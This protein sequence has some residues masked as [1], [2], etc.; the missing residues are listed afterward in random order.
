MDERYAAPKP[1][2]ACAGLPCGELDARF[3]SEHSAVVPQI[4]THIDGVPDVLIQNCE[5][6]ETCV[7]SPCGELYARRPIF[8]P[9][10]AGGERAVALRGIIDDDCERSFHR[11]RIDTTSAYPPMRRGRAPCHTTGELSPI[12]EHALD[13][14]RAC[15]TPLVGGRL[16]LSPKVLFIGG[17]AYDRPHSVEAS[18]TCYE[19]RRG[20]LLVRQIIVHTTSLHL[21]LRYERS[22]RSGN[23]GIIVDFVR[24]LS[25]RGNMHMSHTYLVASCDRCPRSRDGGLLT[26]SLEGYRRWWTYVRSSHTLRGLAS[27][28]PLQDGE[29]VVDFHGSRRSVAGARRAARLGTLDPATKGHRGLTDVLTAHGSRRGS[30]GRVDGMPHL[31]LTLTLKALSASGYTY[32][33][34]APSRARRAGAT[35]DA[36]RRENYCRFPSSPRRVE[37]VPHGARR[38]TLTLPLQ[39]FFVL[40]YAYGLKAPSDA[41]QAC[42]AHRDGRAI[43][44]IS[45]RFF[46]LARVY[47]NPRYP[48]ACVSS[49]GVIE[50]SP[51]G[52]LLV[53]YVL[54]AAPLVQFVL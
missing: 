20:S 25:A 8:D 36:P 14:S 39:A 28:P 4:Y 21:P 49:L 6:P 11:G 52:I 45:S 32:D 18:R 13:K 22:P 33:L 41:P 16:T 10:A 2:E 3:P 44:D 43:V 1:P 9:R 37:G 48:L 7:R 27:A 51:A 54:T 29:I 38:V 12:S 26:V 50:L 23:G 24:R 35:R 42:A 5:P 46:L 17:Y 34:K 15:L 47:T 53:A 40:G 30:H 31:V 19:A